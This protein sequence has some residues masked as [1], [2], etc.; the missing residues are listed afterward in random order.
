MMIQFKISKS[1]AMQECIIYTTRYQPIQ[2]YF[3]IIYNIKSY[4]ELALI[5]FQ[6]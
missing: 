4:F 1:I 3:S 2:C 5:Y 6:F